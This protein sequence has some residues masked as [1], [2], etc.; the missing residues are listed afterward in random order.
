VFDPSFFIDFKL[1]KDPSSCRSA[2]EL[3]DEIQ[4]RARHASALQLNE[5]TS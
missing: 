1:A 2:G 4:R 5:Q 3:P